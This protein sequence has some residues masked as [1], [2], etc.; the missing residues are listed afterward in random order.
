MGR[1]VAAQKHRLRLGSY[2]RVDLIIGYNI[3]RRKT[4][5]NARDALPD[6]YYAQRQSSRVGGTT[7]KVIWRDDISDLISK[8]YSYRERWGYCAIRVAIFPF[9]WLGAPR[10]C[11]YI[12]RVRMTD[13]E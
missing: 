13:R 7:M 6:G 1:L 9:C 12:V 2:S 8:S 4:Q 10:I 11:D 5:N 3:D